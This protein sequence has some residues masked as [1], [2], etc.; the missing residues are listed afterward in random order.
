VSRKLLGG[1]QGG[2]PVVFGCGGWIVDI[3]GLSFTVAR[4]ARGKSGR[5]GP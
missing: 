5:V 1:G 2:G 3:E 4:K